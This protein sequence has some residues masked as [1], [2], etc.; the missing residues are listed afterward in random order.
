MTICARKTLQLIT[1]FVLYKSITNP[2]LRLIKT[3]ALL[4][5]SYNFSEIWKAISVQ[6]IALFCGVIVQSALFRGPTHAWLSLTHSC[7]LRRVAC[8]A[9]TWS[10]HFCRSFAITEMLLQVFPICCISF[11]TVRR[12]VISGRPLLRSPSG[13]QCKAVLAME[14]SWRVTWP[15]H[16]QRLLIRMVAMDSIPHL[17]SR[18][19]LEMVLG[20]KTAKCLTVVD[21]KRST[22]RFEK[23]KEGSPRCLLIY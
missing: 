3:R 16:L 9:A 12:H 10:L 19:L 18:S 23:S 5:S 15:I 11:S 1:S 7:P 17:S 22:P 14:V 13:V 21:V 6:N 8:R 2:A 20:Q 4:C